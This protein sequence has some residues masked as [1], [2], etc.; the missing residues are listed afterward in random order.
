MNSRAFRR[1]YMP[2]VFGFTLLLYS[3]NG[4][5]KYLRRAIISVVEGLLAK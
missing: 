5:V 4:D 2:L 3:S 1:A